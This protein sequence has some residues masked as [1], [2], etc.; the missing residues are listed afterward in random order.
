MPDKSF[1]DTNLWVYLK[2]QNQSPD[3]LRKQQVVQTLILNLP[4]IAVSVQ[5]LN[6][7]ANV[8][9]KK[10]SFPEAST[11]NFLDE[12]C[13]EFE[14]ASLTPDITQ[15]ALGLKSTYLLSWFDSL[16]VAAALHTNCN[17]LYTE[18]MQDGLVIEK[19]LKVVNPFKH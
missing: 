18:D 1:F 5:V 3:D 2:A 15:R 11:G 6:E 10:F 14:V 8:L 19:K 7:V 9:M 13:K 4:E 12:I 17:V 16:I